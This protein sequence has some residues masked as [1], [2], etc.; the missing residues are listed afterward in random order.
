MTMLKVCM[1]LYDLG[2][3]QVPFNDSY[4][5]VGVALSLALPFFVLAGKL[6]DRQ[7]PRFPKSHL[8]IFQIRQETLHDDWNASRSR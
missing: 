3:S 7:V 5:I 2:K 1:R 8:R 4:L 6:S